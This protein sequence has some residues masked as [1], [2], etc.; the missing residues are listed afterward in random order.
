MKLKGW[1]SFATLTALG[2]GASGL[3]SA[4]SAVTFASAEVDQSRFMLLATAGG[5]RLTVLEQVS[6]TRPC[7][8]ESGNNV[9][10][11]LLGFDFTG[12]CNRAS[13]RNGYSVRVGGQDLGLQYSLRTE[14]VGNAMVLYAVSSR[15]GS[16]IEIGRTNGVPSS[17]GKI[18][19]NNGWRITRRS[20]QGRTLGHYYLTND[21]PLGT[22]IAANPTPPST[23]VS[24]PRPTTPTT[25]PVA[26]NPTPNRPGSGP[27][28]IPVPPPASNPAPRPTQPPVSGSPLPPPPSAGRPGDIAVLPVPG[29]PPTPTGHTPGTLPSVPVWQNPVYTGTPQGTSPGLAANLGFSYRVI[30][31]DSSPST[32]MRIRA[33]VPDAF[34]T[35]L[36]GQVVMQAGLF[37]DRPSAEQMMQ[38]LSQAN[39]PATVISVN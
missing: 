11:L 14:T 30:V 13:D 5:S 23:G 29:L 9:E 26:V 6:N 16:R 20:Y 22:V 37:R 32:Q 15:G 21:Q 39:L 24:N 3:F 2:L 36:N 1:L 17:F 28:V 38:R 25:P 19:L 10:P 35:V 27:V 31:R 34:R 8:R 4:A 7:W 33:I 18:N 12:I